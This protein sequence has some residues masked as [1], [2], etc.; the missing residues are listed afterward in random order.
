MPLVRGKARDEQGRD[1]GGQKRRERTSL[2]ST[3]IQHSER[4]LS[5]KASPVWESL[6]ESGKIDAHGQSENHRLVTCQGVCLPFPRLIEV[7]L[8]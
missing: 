1:L 8:I 5:G 4:E 7:L 6:R 2:D 3:S